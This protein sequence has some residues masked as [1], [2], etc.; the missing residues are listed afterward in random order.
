MIQKAC[1]CGGGVIG[2]IPK[3]GGRHLYGAVR[4]MI[5]YY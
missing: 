3:E 2:R 4:I 1:V 5:Y